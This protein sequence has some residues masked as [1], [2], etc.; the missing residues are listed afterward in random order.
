MDIDRWQE[1]DMRRQHIIQNAVEAAD[2]IIMDGSNGD[3]EET[4]YLTGEVANQFVQKVTGRLQ[5]IL[6][7]YDI[8]K[9]HRP[10]PPTEGGTS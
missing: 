4:D 9:R 2:R 5:S 10:K 8:E 6:L 1:E 3:V 7:R